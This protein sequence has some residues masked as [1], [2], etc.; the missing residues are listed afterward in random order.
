MN[1]SSWFPMSV[2]TKKPTPG[3]MF[4]PAKTIEYNSYIYPNEKIKK[5]ET[6]IWVPNLHKTVSLKTYE[7]A[8]QTKD[9]NALNKIQS[10]GIPLNCTFG[11]IINF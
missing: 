5:N 2:Y 3:I 11:G 10:L 1:I 9:Q 8:H 6:V 7:K 4:G